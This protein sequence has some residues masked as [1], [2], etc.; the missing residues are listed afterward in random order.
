MARKARAGVRENANEKK[1]KE[2]GRVWV[3]EEG[4]GCF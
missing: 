1:E 2:R 4:S 3:S